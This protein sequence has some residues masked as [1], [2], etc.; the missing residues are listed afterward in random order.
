MY[1]SNIYNILPCFH[2]DVNITI[3][4]YIKMSSPHMNNIIIVGCVMAYV[5][6]FLLGM[7]GDLVPEGAFK[8]VCKVWVPLLFHSAILLTK[9]I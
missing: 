5:S 1:V 6:I 9:H 2:V 7:D 4:R 8:D 3:Y